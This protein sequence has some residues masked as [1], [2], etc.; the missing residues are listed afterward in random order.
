MITQIDFKAK[1][2]TLAKFIKSLAHSKFYASKELL[3]SLI[4]KVLLKFSLQSQNDC[5]R[6]YV[7]LLKDKLPIIRKFAAEHLKDLAKCVPPIAENDMIVLIQKISN[8]DLDLIRVYIV[9]ALLQLTKNIKSKESTL[10]LL[11]NLCGDS[12][13]R[14]RYA[15]CEA[16]YDVI[17]S[18]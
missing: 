14:V 18:K 5:L 15:V 2:D 8:D 9:Q 1:E 12:S 13:W 6:I 10:N 3:A 7:D 16:L 11:K 4:P 17:F